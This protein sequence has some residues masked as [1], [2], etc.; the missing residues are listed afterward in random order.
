MPAPQE[1]ERVAAFIKERGRIS[2]AELAHKSNDFIV[3]GAETDD[4]GGLPKIDLS[5]EDDE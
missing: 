4:A 2:I 5:L 3:M 1:M